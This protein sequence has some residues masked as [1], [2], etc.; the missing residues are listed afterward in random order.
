MT[1]GSRRLLSILILVGRGGGLKGILLF[2]LSVTLALGFPYALPQADAQ[3][4]VR[5]I[6]YLS[7]GPPPGGG[8]HPI[9]PFREGLLEV[10]YVVGQ[11]LVMD[12]R[13]ASGKDHLLP[14]LA[15]DLVRRNAD[16]IVT[17]GDQATAAAA[18]AT[19]DI[20]IV[21]AV[22]T[23]PVGIGLVVS[24]ARPGGNITG[25]TTISPELGGKRLDL[26]KQVVPRVSRIAV[27]WNA[28]NRGKAAELRE[29]ETAAHRLA[30]T[31]WSIEI[32]GQADFERA[33][34]TINRERA[35]A[36]STLRE[37]LIQGHQKQIVQFAARSRLPDMHVGSE[38]A[39]DGGLMAYGP[40]VREIFRRSAV[41]VDK[42]LRG[43]KPADLPIEQPTRFEL[44]INLKTA[45]TL[46]LTIPKSVLL[47]ADR[48][49]E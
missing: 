2:G 45:K 25:L 44:V 23:D 24:L 43:A 22:S 1:R 21:T 13:Y 9:E 42:I 33:F 4:K 14:D 17:V 11:S 8:F 3:G 41:Y 37:P 39:D 36:L 30:I 47:Q 35:D 31:V 5:H 26:L 15:A 29:L 28:N 16:L 40:S 49:I 18:K 20:P 6:G 38:W 7:P 46:G 12:E 27:L 34:R 32:R 19:R 48:V 10:G